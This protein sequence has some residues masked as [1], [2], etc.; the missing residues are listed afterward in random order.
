MS[1]RPD[2][3]NKKVSHFCR[4]VRNKPNQL[5][6]ALASEEQPKVYRLPAPK[7]VRP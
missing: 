6:R 1:H 5:L 3:V 4:A 7:K 2:V